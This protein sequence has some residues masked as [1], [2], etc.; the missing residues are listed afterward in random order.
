MALLTVSF[1]LYIPIHSKQSLESIMN[2]E[3]YIPFLLLK[4]S[5]HS[6]RLVTLN[7]GSFLANLSFLLATIWQITQRILLVLNCESKIAPDN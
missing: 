7:T 2:V 5:T 1:F 3:L 6:R 4:I